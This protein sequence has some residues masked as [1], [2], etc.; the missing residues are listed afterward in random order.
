MVEDWDDG[1]EGWMDMGDGLVRV[2]AR[3]LEGTFDDGVVELIQLYR[4]NIYIV[5]PRVLFLSL[6]LSISEQ[7]SGLFRCEL[8]SV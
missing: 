8:Q 5:F 4:L 1:C 3:G 2:E 6:C 7:F